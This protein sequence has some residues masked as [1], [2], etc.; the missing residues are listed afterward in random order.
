MIDINYQRY[1]TLRFVVK[2]GKV[3]A[4]CGAFIVAAGGIYLAYNQQ[5]I[6]IGIISIVL[7]AIVYGLL[8]VLTELVSVIS[9][10]LLPK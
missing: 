7:A 3:L 8:A 4:I 10:M 6:L 2:Y 9:D 1:E 5:S